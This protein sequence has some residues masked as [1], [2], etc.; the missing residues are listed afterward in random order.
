V[1]SP[2]THAA[3]AEIRRALLVAILLSGLLPVPTLAASLTVAVVDESG[4]VVADAVVGLAPEAGQTP[5]PTQGGS[6]VA[7]RGHRFVPFVLAVRTGTAVEFPNH[8]DTRHHVYSFSPAKTFEIELYRGIPESPIVFDEAGVVSLGCNIHDYMQAFVYVTDAPVFGVTGEDGRVRFDD[9]PPGPFTV[10]VRHPWDASDGAA[11]EVTLE[12]A[13]EMDVALD[14]APP[15]PARPEEN[16][17][18]QWVQQE[19]PR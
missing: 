17:L 5:T 7:Q 3:V 8:D 1:R 4:A 12:G 13:L 19:A 18:R 6:V 10:R 9:L 14:L 16:A 15:P 2:R 11:R